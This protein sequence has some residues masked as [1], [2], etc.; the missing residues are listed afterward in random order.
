MD[1]NEIFLDD[2]QGMK[3]TLQTSHDTLYICI[4]IF[5]LSCVYIKMTKR[6]T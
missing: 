5:V 6:V 1:E 4:Y 2:N 3:Q